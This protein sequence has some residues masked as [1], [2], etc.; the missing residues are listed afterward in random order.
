MLAITGLVTFGCDSVVDHNSPNTADIQQQQFENSF[1]VNASELLNPFTQSELDNNWVADRTFPTG[2]VE[3]VSFDGRDNVAKI[4]VVADEQSTLG[5]FYF[6]EGIKKV[7]DFGTHVQADLYVPSEWQDAD[8]VNVGLWTFDDPPS[9]Y[10]II[11][12][13]NNDEA[14]AGFYTYTYEFDENGDFVADSYVLS[15]VPVNYDGWNTLAISL[16]TDDGQAN[17]SING[18]ETG[19]IVAGGDYI[20]TVF[21]NHYNDG[22]ISYD[23]YWHA[24][25]ANPSEKN[26]CKKGSWAEFGFSNQGQCIRFVNTGKDSR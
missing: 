14:D 22:V 25:F 3:S 17:Y 1:S 8:V 11:V 21:L 2:G 7:G 19:S 16:D 5:S 4:G 20:Q 18:I 13:R 26:D 23:A 9:A 15:D 10:P 6:F 24:G 12:Y